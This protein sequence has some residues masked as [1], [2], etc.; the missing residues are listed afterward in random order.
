MISFRSIY[1]IE[2]NFVFAY[3]KIQLTPR[4]FELPAAAIRLTPRPHSRQPKELIDFL[5]EKFEVRDSNA[6]F[7]VPNNQIQV[8]VK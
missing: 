8:Y 3:C 1:L 4:P 6:E 7:R 5:K 2:H